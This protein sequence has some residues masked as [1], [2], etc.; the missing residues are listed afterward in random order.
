MTR[1]EE[2]QAGDSEATIIHAYLGIDSLA[3][4]RFPCKINSV[5]FSNDILFFTRTN[6]VSVYVC[7]CACACFFTVRQLIAQSIENMSEEKKVSYI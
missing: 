6:E 1:L 5:S 3:Y 2:K 7:A 4:E